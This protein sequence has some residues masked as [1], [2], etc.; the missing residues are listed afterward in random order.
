VILSRESQ[1]RW[2]ELIV[3]ATQPRGRPDGRGGDI[4]AQVASRNPRHR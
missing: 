4:L 2:E 1:Y 3:L